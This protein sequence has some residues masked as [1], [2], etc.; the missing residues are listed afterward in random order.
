MRAKGGV[1]ASA[2]RWR[3]VCLAP[4]TRLDQMCLHRRI[5]AAMTKHGVL[6]DPDASIR[7]ALCKCQVVVSV[8]DASIPAGVGGPEGDGVG[9]WGRI[10]R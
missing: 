4:A 9:I 8:E 5:E 6:I 2:G 10:G 3:I 7:G 1:L